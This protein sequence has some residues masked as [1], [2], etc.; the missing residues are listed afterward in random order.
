MKRTED[1]K[2]ILDAVI[3]HRKVYIVPQA[4]EI[5]GSHDHDLDGTALK[6]IMEALDVKDA[7]VYILGEDE[8]LDDTRPVLRQG[9]PYDGGEITW[10]A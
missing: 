1:L 2:E 5:C 4:Y 10:E 3:G 8:I 7:D 9:M 6:E